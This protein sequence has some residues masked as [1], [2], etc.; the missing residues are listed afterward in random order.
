MSSWLSKGLRSLSQKLATDE[1]LSDGRDLFK[2]VRAFMTGHSP[3]IFDVNKD[4]LN[5]PRAKLAFMANP[6][7]GVRSALRP[8][9]GMPIQVHPGVLSADPQFDAFKFELAVELS[10]MYPP[11][12]DDHGFADETAVTRDYS[13]LLTT[14]GLKMGQANVPPKDRSK[15]LADAGIINGWAS[16]RHKRIGEALHRFIFGHRVPGASAHF[17]LASSTT[18]PSHW[19]GPG[20]QLQKQ[21][22]FRD[23]ATNVDDV[24]RLVDDTNLLELY[25]RYGIMNLMKLVERQQSEGV[26][27]L[28]GGD[29]TP[30]KRLV[31][32]FE[33]M[34]TGGHGGSRIEA[35]KTKY[36]RDMFGLKY[37]VGTRVRTAYGLCGQINALMT[38]VLAGSREYYFDEGEYTWH[39]TT[40]DQIYDGIRDFVEIIGFDATT[41]DQFF[42]TFF[43]QEHVRLLGDY[44]DPRYV[45]LVN[46]VNGAPYYAPQLGENMDPFFVGDPRDPDSFNVDVGLSSGR[47]DNPDL[48]KWYMTTVYLCLLD[49]FTHDLLE[50][51]GNDEQSIAQVL[52]GRHPAFGLKD[53]G[54][55]AMVGFK[56]G[57]ERLAAK[58]RDELRKEGEREKAKICPYARL[59]IEMGIAFLGNVIFKDRMGQIQIPKP[60]PVTFMANRH[61][62][63]RGINTGMRQFW[64]HG[65]EAAIE[66]YSRAGD[67]IYESLKLERELWRK[68]MPGY[69]TPEQMSNKAMTL[70]PLPITSSLSYA[71][72]EVIL[73]PTKL[74]Y[75][76][77][78]SDVSED[79][80]SLFTS[81][82]E[83]EFIDKHMRRIWA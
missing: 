66:H 36:T 45:K 78:P 22:M 79:I 17:Q 5:D 15:M 81:T 2:A 25:R 59:D 76:Y 65:M 83:G 44:F 1:V 67:V 82:I 60:N 52:K 80:A 24:L 55:D 47:A 40:P 31:A 21:F 19:G 16:P 69:P 10:K 42:P 53:M 18:A 54:D 64:G 34:M 77:K 3:G 56:A 63:E 6:T 58:F 32:D 61:C 12:I 75:K 72:M 20:S 13:A 51:G 70:K 8:Y 7:P 46:W 49:D 27:D 37:G 50:Q 39:H 14:S 48:G 9:V 57:Y 23:L 35:S 38:M 33:Y 43:L 26:I 28:L 74:F 11:N 73:D 68:W 41:M 30:K 71:E 29:L 62:P 4:I